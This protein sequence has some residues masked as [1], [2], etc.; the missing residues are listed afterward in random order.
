MTRRLF[1]KCHIYLHFHPVDKPIRDPNQADT[2][3]KGNGPEI[4]TP[5]QNTLLLFERGYFIDNILVISV[6]KKLG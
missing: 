1:H 6:V 3:G 4:R 5:I 2:L